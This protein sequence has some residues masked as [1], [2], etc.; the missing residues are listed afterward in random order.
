MGFNMGL[1]MAIGK[2]AHGVRKGVQGH[3]TSKSAGSA[4]LVDPT[5]AAMVNLMH[6]ERR[7]IETGSGGAARAELGR[8]TKTLMRRSI[9]AGKRD[10]SDYSKFRAE[11]E[12][13][14][15][16]GSATE[17]LGL[18]KHINEETRNMA[19]R[20]MDL[21][22]LAGERKRVSGE[23]TKSNAA[24]NVAS[25]LPALQNLLQTQMENTATQTS[26]SSGAD[27]GGASQNTKNKK[28][29]GGLFKT[30]I[31][32]GKAASKAA[33][34]ASSGAGDAAGAVGSAASSGADAAS[35]G[36]DAASSGADAL[37]AVAQ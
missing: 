8:D 29:L 14:I 18:L 25:Q 15:V 13:A 24:K 17:R 21:V 10:L 32:G 7:A 1:A 16:Q 9:L 33:G 34:N 19:D 12:A 22:E 4:A 31:G 35:S 36:I 6:R 37:G 30:I 2:M 3:M 27:S 26:K 11:N 5:Q 20:S 28:F 23:A